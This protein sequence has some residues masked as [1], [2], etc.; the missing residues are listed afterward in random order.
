MTDNRL[1]SLE[2]WTEAEC[3]IAQKMFEKFGYVH[4]TFFTENADGRRAGV[5]LPNWGGNKELAIA[6]LRA[7]FKAEGIL[8]YVSFSEAWMVTRKPDEP[9]PSDLSNQPDRME[10][11][12]VHSEE[13]GAPPLLGY[14]EVKR[15]TDGK[16][17]FDLPTFRR[18]PHSTG[19]MTRLLGEEAPI[20]QA[21]QN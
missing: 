18:D 2:D 8:R 4:P 5:V 1:V 17:T 20:P 21:Q 10:I 19:R 3:R 15:P 9:L 16:P 6:V 11:I 7:K 14:A 13:L 12:M